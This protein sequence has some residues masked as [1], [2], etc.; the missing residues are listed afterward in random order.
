VRYIAFIRSSTKKYDFT[1]EDKRIL[2]PR[3]FEIEGKG[4]W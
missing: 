3:K 4:V 1:E 2:Y